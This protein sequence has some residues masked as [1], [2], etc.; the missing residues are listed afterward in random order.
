MIQEKPIPPQ[1]L[2]VGPMTRVKP[3]GAS[4]ATGQGDWCACGHPSEPFPVE[5]LRT[6]TGAE[7]LSLFGGEM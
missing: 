6:C 7:M 2:R 3:M 1:V 4:R 5:G